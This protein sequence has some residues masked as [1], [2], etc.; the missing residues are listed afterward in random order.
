MMDY[1]C[2]GVETHNPCSFCEMNYVDAFELSKL[3]G[4]NTYI[5]FSIT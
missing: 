4:S 1:G 2:V 3:S 5:A